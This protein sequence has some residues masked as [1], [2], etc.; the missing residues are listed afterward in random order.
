[1]TLGEIVARRKKCAVTTREA[2]LCA[3]RQRFLQES[4]E[5]VG[6][7][8]IARD[9]GVDVALVGRYFGS[10]EEL[11][12]EV[13]RSGKS[14]TFKV[15]L[16]ASD[17]PAYLA[18]LSERTDG[19]DGRDHADGL[20][21]MLRSASSPTAA[22]IV[23]EAVCEDVLGPIAAMLEGD[24]AE[25]RASL[26]LAVLMGTA[27]LRTIMTVEPSC[28][29]GRETL[30]RKLLALFRTAL[31]DDSAPRPLGT[32]FDDEAGERQALPARREPGQ[33]GGGINAEAGQQH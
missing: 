1:M 14:D 2:M 31:A 16:S 17:L 21:I 20:L 27:I 5:N 29:G 12:K 18:S 33:D 4:Y 3:A 26:S 7:R 28:A 22:R 13:L 32:A 19:A 9:V 6:L 10:K 25:A 11:F 15:D 30:N 23:R 8:D 24:D